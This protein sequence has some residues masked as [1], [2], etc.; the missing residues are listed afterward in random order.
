MRS[1]TIAS[2]LIISMFWLASCTAVPTSVSPDAELPSP[3]LAATN[4][5]PSVLLFTTPTQMPPS[6]ISPS[7]LKAMN[8][9]LIAAAEAGDI[10]VVTHL[11]QAGVDV[12]AT[13]GTDRTAVMAATHANQ[14]EIVRMLI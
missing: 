12:N 3:S 4:E 5:Q 14:V 10:A 1:S 11:L 2:S 9:E 8:A 13:D 7:E 6:A